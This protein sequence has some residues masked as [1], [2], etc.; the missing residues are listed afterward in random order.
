MEVLESSKLIQKTYYVHGQDV[1]RVA[2]L[3]RLMPN[4]ATKS[5]TQIHIV[6]YFYETPDKLLEELGASIRVR[7]L[8]KEQI[9]SM[10]YHKEGKRREFEMQME[11]GDKIQDKNEY[12]LFLEDKLQDIY[13]HTID[14]DIARMLKNLKV[15]LFITTERTQLEIFNNTG[16]TGIVN[17]D[18]VLFSTKRHNVGENI[19]EIKQTCLNDVA[20]KIAFE[21]FYH[22]LEQKVLLTPMDETKFDAGKR[23][24]RAE[25]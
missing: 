17:F 1:P 2:E 4:Y 19:L 11:L 5:K 21:R 13:T 15:F 10:V 18:A 23:V 20:N 6:D 3:I 16:F 8:E 7:V 22:A 24:F 9:L 12:I 14:V 25:Y